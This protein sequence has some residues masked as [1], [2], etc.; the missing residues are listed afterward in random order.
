MR[1]LSRGDRI[2]SRREESNNIVGG[3]DDASQ[4]WTLC[5]IAY[6]VT[7]SAEGAESRTQTGCCKAHTKVIEMHRLRRDH[8]EKYA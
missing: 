5:P 7:D 8:S 1:Q 2:D 3:D 6:C 4:V